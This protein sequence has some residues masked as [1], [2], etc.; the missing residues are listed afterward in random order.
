M[1]QTLQ[2]KQGLQLA[3]TPQLQQAIRLMQ[4]SST[5]LEQEIQQM[6]D[7]NPLLE[8]GDSYESE[9]TPESHEHES[10]QDEWSDD[11]PEELSLD[12]Q[13]DELYADRDI[14]EESVATKQSDLSN[15]QQDFY[16]DTSSETLHESLLWQVTMAKLVD[17]DRAIALTIIDSLAATGLLSIS[18]QALFE[19]IADELE[20]DFADF[21]AVRGLI[22]SFEPQGC[23]CENLVEFLNYRLD[24]LPKQTPSRKEAKQLVNRHLDALAIHDY[25]QL[26]RRTGLSPEAI[27][28]ALELIQR[29]S[30]LPSE[31]FVDTNI[32][33]IKPDVYVTKRGPIWQAQLSSNSAIKLRINTD[34]A[35]LIN[36]AKNTQ[37]QTYIRDNL[38]EAK[39]F[40]KSLE[41]RNDTLLKVAQTIVEQQHGFFDYGEQAMKPLI[42]QDVAQAIDMHES[43]VSRIT[44]RKYMQTPMGV[45]EL[46]YF[47]S[48]HVSTDTGGECSSIAIRSMIKKLVDEEDTKKPLSD[49]KLASLLEEQG[50]N[51]ARRTIAKYR[52]QLQIPPSNERKRL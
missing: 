37:D 24:T 47:F 38:N 50:I 15:S 33:Y 18:A 4:L 2:L 42:L 34:Y 44:T 52:E 31:E 29:L 36:R 3:L 14:H 26:K 28:S 41:S 8:S 48:S 12:T 45:F 23:A 32:E 27:K 21:E 10:A 39:W 22:K 17:Q 5:E 19:S 11:I 1:K 16:P 25:A 13:W 20:I 30:N 6:L 35:E 43:T 49:S 51:I 7:S 40:I 9:D 46:K